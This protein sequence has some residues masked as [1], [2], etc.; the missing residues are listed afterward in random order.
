MVGAVAGRREGEETGQGPASERRGRRNGARGVARRCACN[1]ALPIRARTLSPSPSPCVSSFSVCPSLLSIYLYSF[2][3]RVA[4]R[5]PRHA[6]SPS[7]SPVAIR[8]ARFRVCVLRDGPR[9][10]E[11]PRTEDALLCSALLCF[12]LLHCVR[13]R[14]A[15]SATSYDVILKDAPRVSFVSVAIRYRLAIRSRNCPLDWLRYSSLIAADG[16]MFPMFSGAS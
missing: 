15:T 2:L 16:K 12:A 7:P 4:C 9:A 14:R 13:P 10:L 3:I 1:S 6:P 8:K 11:R 5:G